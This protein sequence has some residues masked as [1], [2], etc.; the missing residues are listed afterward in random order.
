MERDSRVH[1]PFS[2]YTGECDGKTFTGAHATPDLFLHT[3]Q[4]GVRIATT[5]F[6][7]ELSEEPWY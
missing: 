7:A 2:E 1:R 5:E 3:P 6:L 4:A